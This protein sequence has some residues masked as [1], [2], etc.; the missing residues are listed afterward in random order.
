M[1]AV[2]DDQR[3]EIQSAAGWPEFNQRLRR[4]WAVETGL[5][6]RIYTLDRGITAT[7]IERGIDA[8][9]IP[10]DKVGVVSAEKAA[11][12][13]SD[14]KDVIDGI[15]D[16]VGGTREISV[17]YIKELHAA[18][19]RNQ[20]TATGVDQFGTKTEVP[21]IKGDYK[22]R[23]NNPVRGDGKGVHEY[24][25]PEQTASE[26]GRLIEMHRQHTAANVAPEVE[27]AWLHHRFAQIHPFQDGNGRVARSLATLVFL[28]AGL[29]PLIVRD[30]NGE[31][32]KYIDALESADRGDLKPLV[33]IFVAYQQREFIRAFDISQRILHGDIRKLSRFSKA[34]AEAIIK[35]AAKK[36]A[37]RKGPQRQEWA[38]AK[39]LALK[40]HTQAEKSLRQ[41][42]ETLDASFGVGVS[43][44]EKLFRVEEYSQDDGG[45]RDFFFRDM[46]LAMELE[47]PISPET[48]YSW[49]R[50]TLR[51]GGKQAEIVIFFHGIGSEYRGILGCS[52]GFFT[53]YRK[54]DGRRLFSRAQP[55]SDAVFQINYQDSERQTVK[56]F[57]EWL[58]GA[59]ERGLSLWHLSL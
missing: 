28:R 40:L 1:H 30:I 55:L 29:F 25:P 11:A 35:S 4:E 47:Y 2:W 54:E 49:L 20:D 45:E 13:I 42:K 59:L 27:A 9:L 36:I 34:R 22:K 24:C 7:L 48:Y 41:I 18:L 53:I 51:P 37:A 19:V 16:F 8:A 43:S 46:I 58:D 38:K 3:E 17:S 57:R 56:G 14:H 32:G 23:P 26:M 5:I 6:E 50:L 31:R 52:A 21:L 44:D 10:H 39:A 33:K 12:M 15:F